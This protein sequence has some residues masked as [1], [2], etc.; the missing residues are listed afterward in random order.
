MPGKSP[1]ENVFDLLAAT[2]A[3]AP[4]YKRLIGRMTDTPDQQIIIYDTG[5][6]SPNPAYL[7]N[8][9]SVQVRVRGPIDG[10]AE[11]WA[12]AKSVQDAL[13][14]IQPVN[15]GPDHIDGIIGIGD[16]S[17]LLWDQSNRPH[18][19]LNFRLFFEPGT[20]TNRTSL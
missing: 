8:Y 5:G 19:T 6:L 12:K 3:A 2:A 9:Y 13:L 4:V 11:G 15:V 10:Y 20:G 1:A 17:Y 18:F 16:I 7:I 14:G